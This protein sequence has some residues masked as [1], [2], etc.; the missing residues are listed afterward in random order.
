MDWKVT[1]TESLS[2]S[3]GSR[4]RVSVGECG[5]MEFW[6]RPFKIEGDEL[7]SKWKLG[8]AL[9]YDERNYAAQI[10]IL[11]DTLAEA[12]ADADALLQYMQTTTDDPW[13]RDLEGV[14]TV[15]LMV[16]IEEN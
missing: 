1:A 16:R 10:E 15:P 13:D 12:T 3:L 11:Y 2:I 5:E 7:Y 6:I 4:Q 9:C 14:P 8:L